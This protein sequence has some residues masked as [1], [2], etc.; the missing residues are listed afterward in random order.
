MTK[1]SNG[2]VRTSRVQRY[3]R[4]SKTAEDAFC[5]ALRTGKSIAAAASAAGVGRRTVYGWRENDPAFAAGWD[6]AFEVGSDYLED[7][8][9]QRAEAGSERLLL[10]LLRARRPGRFARTVVEHDGSLEVVI[11]NA[12]ETLHAKLARITAS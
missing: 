1:A 12:K 2:T 10:A 3:G 7:L 9:L 11:Q 6:E 4:R 8:A 5:T